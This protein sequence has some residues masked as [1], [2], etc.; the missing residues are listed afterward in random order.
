MPI[1]SVL[2]HACRVL[3]RT[4]STRAF[5]VTFVVTMDAPLR[6]PFFF[7]FA[8]CFFPS[9][10]FATPTSLPEKA[11][12][13]YYGSDIPWSE[14]ALYDYAV[15]ESDHATEAPD[16]GHEYYAYVSVGE[17]VSS[18]R[19]FDGLRAE[20]LL[21]RNPAWGSHVL[22]QGNPALREYFIDEVIA[23]LWERGY[24]RFFLDTLDSYRLIESDEAGWQHQR[25]G[26]V[27]LINA[28]AVRYPQARFIFN[29]GFELMPAMRANVDAIAVESLYQRWQPSGNRYEAVS[30][31]DREWLLN[32]LTKM[33]DEHGVDVISIDYAAPAER[34]QARDIAAKIAAHGVIPW[35]TDPALDTLGLGLREV[36][37]RRVLMIHGGTQERTWELSSLV[38]YALMPVQFKGL[39]PDIRGIDE[40]MP[41]GSLAGRYAGIV[42]W[43]EASGLASDDFERW[44]LQQKETGIPIA[45]LGYPAVDPNG[46]LAADFG[47]KAQPIAEQL[48]LVVE[49]HEAVGFELPVPKLI[50]L[51]TPLDS[52]DAT[53]WLRLQAGEQFYAPVAMT[54][55]GGY[56][57]APFT[58]Y[59]VEPDTGG[60]STDRWLINPLTFMAEALKLPPMPIPDVTTENG[61][62]L[63]FAHMDGDGF[64]SLAEIDGYA[65]QTDAKVLL[66]EIL[67]KFS[68]PTTISVIESEVSTSGLYPDLATQM[69]KVARAMYRLPHVEA[70]THTYS[71]PFYWYE[72]QANPDAMYLGDE[73]LRLLVKDYQFS[74]E[75][76][77]VGSAKF[78]DQNLLPKGKRTEMVLW[79]GD[80]IPTPEALRA[81]RL[82]GLLNMNGSDTIITRS[83]PTWTAIKGIGIPKGSEY[84]VYAPNQNENI[85][86]NDW[87]GPFYGF[88]RVIETFELTE[89]PLRFKPVNIYYHTYIASKTASLASLRRVYQWADKQPLFPLFASDYAR[90]VLDFNDMV[91]ARDGDRWW[92]RGGGKLRTLRF[93]LA[94]AL[95]DID[96]S[97]GLAGYLV[98]KPGRYVH[99]VD[100]SANWRAG[101]TTLPYLAQ[102]NG[103]ITHF[104]RD[105]DGSLLLSL[106]AQEPLIFTL[107][108]AEGCRLSQENNDVAGQR[109]SGQ[110]LTVRSQHSELNALRLRCKP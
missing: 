23:P 21:G 38:R 104:Q 92:V 82:G 72:A 73:Q 75:R 18:R 97:H 35:V 96:H 61:R 56:A 33:R 84:Q 93:P 102:A 17:A 85:Y 48:P 45:M 8:L 52:P 110:Q 83:E 3:R 34:Q 60:K 77:T 49:Q 30:P 78:I 100:G 94:L 64:P 4:S 98:D 90:K 99:M 26:L 2:L 74:V 109:L 51:S 103:R 16:N 28:I 66:D 57:F 40:A 68:L 20:W 80:T 22:D 59:P 9:A 88:D 47:F 76:E 54:D 10:L 36:I 11:A 58:I 37:P 1:F 14:L 39:V 29:R 95:P 71:H 6:Q 86:T 24:R 31:E 62:R 65:G 50:D 67:T 7:I 46:S 41:T 13:F 53:P 108:N 44:L 55:W 32:K 107:A 87:R 27:A 70:A 79:S 15:V 101:S 63:G 25:E 89:T 69:Q 43:L 105:A 19:Y 91:I 42:I 12:A 5:V 106:S 81:S